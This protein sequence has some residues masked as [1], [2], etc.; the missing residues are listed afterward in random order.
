MYTYL[1]KKQGLGADDFGGSTG[2]DW[3]Y[4]GYDAAGNTDASIGMPGAQAASLV[5]APMQQASATDWLKKNQN[6][7]LG[8]VGVAVVLKLMAGRR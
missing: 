5:H 8:A 3:D 4:Y 2:Y 6:L 1:A 7:V